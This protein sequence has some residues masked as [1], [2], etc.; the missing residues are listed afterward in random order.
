MQAGNATNIRAKESL[1][2]LDW[3]ELESRVDGTNSKAELAIAEDET[4][5][6]RPRNDVKEYKYMYMF[7]SLML[8]RILQILH[9]GSK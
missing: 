5:L 3:D 8:H 7:M 1:D 6:S 9:Q 4:V 2:Y